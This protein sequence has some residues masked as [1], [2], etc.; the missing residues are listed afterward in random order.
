MMVMMM[1][2]MMMMEGWKGRMAA[3][4]QRGNRDRRFNKASKR[5]QH[6][7]MT[8]AAAAAAA[9]IKSSGQCEYIY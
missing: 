9:K 8:V 5:R 2:K 7:D 1:M 3:C 6:V 4:I